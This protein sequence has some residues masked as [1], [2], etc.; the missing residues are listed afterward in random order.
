VSSRLM[1]MRLRRLGRNTSPNRRTL[2]HGVEKE[3]KCGAANIAAMQAMQKTNVQTITDRQTPVCFNLAISSNFA[4]LA[5][6]YAT[7]EITTK[8]H[9]RGIAVIIARRLRRQC[10]KRVE[11]IVR[12]STKL[13]SD[14]G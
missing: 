6:I 11:N 8:W 1:R 2:C 12:P 14:E 4:E 5:R 10:H 3:T 7:L 13:Q 9:S